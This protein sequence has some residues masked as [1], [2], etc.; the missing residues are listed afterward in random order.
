MDL[1]ER[2]KG[3]LMGLA[4]GDALGAPLESKP[5]GTFEP[6]N[7]MIGGGVFGLKPGE[8][9][10][11]TS[12]ALCL[13]ESLIMKK[14]FD[15]IDQLERY[16]KWY[17]TGYLSSQSQSFGIGPTATNSLKEFEITHKPIRQT[18]ENAVTNGSLMRLAPVP[19]AFAKKPEIAIKKSGD[20]S[21][22][23][24]N[25]KIAVD[26]CRY[27]AALI[28]GAL[29]NVSKNEFLTDF[30]TPVNGYWENNPLCPEIGEVAAG[31]FRKKEPPEIQ[32]ALYVPRT[33]E[34]ALWAFYKCS[35][36]KEGCLMAVN[37]GDDADTTGAI[38]GQL[39]GAYYGE[40][41]IP[42]SWCQKLVY[43]DLIESNAEKLMY[44]DC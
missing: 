18:N 23:T 22:T 26:A 5:P 1:V 42:E 25:S 31:S 30:Y 36:F 24:H 37:L 6:I 15:P 7:D 40:K 2:Y 14:S 39:A 8:W 34:S 4:V 28:I 16:L 9:T 35:S 10:D 44:V 17:K 41:N 32:A 12:Q 20:S 21:R 3:A 13:A 29:N 11:D 43:R 27:M 33:L 38:Y 19:L